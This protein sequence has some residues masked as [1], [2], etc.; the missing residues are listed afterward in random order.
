MCRGATFAGPAC[1]LPRGYS[2]I[3]D[4]MGGRLDVQYVYPKMYRA[5]TG[6]IFLFFSFIPKSL[7]YHS[8]LLIPWSHSVYMVSSKTGFETWS[9]PR[10]I[11][12]ESSMTWPT[13]S[14]R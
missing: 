13:K 9:S 11:S 4:L 8:G 5:A 6:E 1:R 2:G 3:F 10:N 14:D 12:K 7:N